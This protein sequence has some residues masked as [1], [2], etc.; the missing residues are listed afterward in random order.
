M[1]KIY[2]PYYNICLFEVDTYIGFGEEADD[3]PDDDAPHAGDGREP[4]VGHLVQ[5]EVGEGLGG[6]HHG[7]RGVVQPGIGTSH[8]TDRLLWG[9]GRSVVVLRQLRRCLPEPHPHREDQGAQ[10]SNKR[11]L[12]IFF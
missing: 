10:R 12:N 4:H 5:G 1:K 8:D 2:T 9:P 11:T 3:N 6:S 7:G